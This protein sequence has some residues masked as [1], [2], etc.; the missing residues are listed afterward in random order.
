[1]I[2][3]KS[4]TTSSNYGAVFVLLLYLLSYRDTTVQG[5]TLQPSVKDGQII[6]EDSP[7]VFF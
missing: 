7:L 3:V 1:M 2:K 6:F 5:L 4:F